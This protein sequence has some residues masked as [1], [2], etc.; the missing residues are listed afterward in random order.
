MFLFS[1]I[2]QT[3]H[4]FSGLLNILKDLFGTVGTKLGYKE[5]SLTFLGPKRDPEIEP[6]WATD[7]TKCQSL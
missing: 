3:E 1:N 5:P 2:F 7:S 4:L 6:L